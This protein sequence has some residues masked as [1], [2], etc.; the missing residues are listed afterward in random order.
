MNL[1]GKGVKWMVWDTDKSHLDPYIFMRKKKKVWIHFSH[2]IL[3][4]LWTPGFSWKALHWPWRTVHIRAIFSKDSQGRRTDSDALSYK[5]WVCQIL[6]ISWNL[7]KL[8]KVWSKERFGSE[9]DLWYKMHPTTPTHIPISRCGT[10]LT[11]AFSGQ[12]TFCELCLH[13]GTVVFPDYFLFFS[14]DFFKLT[15]FSFACVGSSLLLVGFL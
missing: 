8:S 1:L 6:I 4:F 12:C 13:H 9:L 10:G 7:T 3:P 5:K 14:K 2:L 11:P 15:Y